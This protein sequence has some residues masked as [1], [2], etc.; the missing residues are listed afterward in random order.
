METPEPA[1]AQPETPQTPEEAL[2]AKLQLALGEAAEMQRQL[3]DIELEKKQRE[4][5][6]AAERQERMDK[7][8]ARKL[9]L[10]QSPGLE[11]AQA[12]ACRIHLMIDPRVLEPEFEYKKVPDP[13]PERIFYGSALLVNGYEINDTLATH[14]VL[15]SVGVIT[16]MQNCMNEEQTETTATA[17]FDLPDGTVQEVRLDVEAGFRSGRM[18]PHLDHVILAIAADD[19]PKLSLVTP[20]QMKYDM[21]IPPPNRPVF[22]A[23]HSKDGETPVDLLEWSI[24]SYDRHCLQYP[25]AYWNEYACE[26]AAV[27]DKFGNL[28]GVH[29]KGWVAAVTT[30][31]GNTTRDFEIPG[32]THQVC[33]IS[34]IVEDILPWEKKNL[35]HTHCDRELGGWGPKLKPKPPKKKTWSQSQGKMMTVAD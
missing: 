4:E 29:F 8:A 17:T 9:L 28:V 21:A 3:E 14:C 15:T 13:K 33:N 1:S 6:E 32:G 5:A 23:S 12:A 31:P 26:G 16:Y 10:Q 18:P 2:Q 19:I 27:L 11:N 22:L 20:V 24:S 25:E 7:I 34:A 35:D 30:G